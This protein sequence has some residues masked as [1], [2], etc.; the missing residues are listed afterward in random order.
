MQPLQLVSGQRS[1]RV[2]GGRQI[3][4]ALN[5]DGVAVE[6]ESSR[7]PGRWLHRAGFVEL[8]TSAACCV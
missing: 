8:A 4:D 5:A 6:A 2:C 1:K 7:D 3:S